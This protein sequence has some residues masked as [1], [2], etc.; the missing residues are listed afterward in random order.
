MSP[1]D[2]TVLVSSRSAS[3]EYSSVVSE[4]VELSLFEEL[5]LEVSDEVELEESLVAVSDVVDP[6]DVVELSVVVELSLV[7]SVELSLVV[8]VEVEFVE[9]SESSWINKLLSE[10]SSMRTGFTLREAAQ[11]THRNAKSREHFNITYS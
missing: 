5:L 7:V 2:S 6:S 1:S 8:S 3:F 10:A 4:L 11:S 9:E